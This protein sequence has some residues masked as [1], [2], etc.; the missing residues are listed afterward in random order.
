MNRF[1][2]Y[3]AYI[4]L[5]SSK[6][7]FTPSGGGS[8]KVT[9]ISNSQLLHNQQL[10]HSQKEEVLIRIQMYAIIGMRHIMYVCVYMHYVC[11]YNIDL[12]II[13]WIQKKTKHLQ[14][15]DHIFFVNGL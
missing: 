12:S 2:S 15:W 13:A 8:S 1:I 7:L 11:V 3:Y 4:I 14:K 6:L 10:K 9:R 5:R